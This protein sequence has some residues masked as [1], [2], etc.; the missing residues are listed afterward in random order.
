MLLVV[1]YWYKK[2]VQNQRQLTQAHHHFFAVFLRV[3]RQGWVRVHRHGQAAQA[4]VSRLPDC[5]LSRCSQG[6]R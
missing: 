5:V 3:E 6:S 2:A 1:Q 4:L